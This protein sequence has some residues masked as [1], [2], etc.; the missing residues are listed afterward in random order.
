MV[1]AYEAD[2]G[3]NMLEGGSNITPQGTAPL[4]V[5]GNGYYIEMIRKHVQFESAADAY[6]WA[7]LQGSPTCEIWLHNEVAARRTASMTV[8]VSGNTA[9]LEAIF[10][11]R[12]DASD[13][14]NY[15]NRFLLKVLDVVD[16]ISP[17]EV[18]YVTAR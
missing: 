1:G 7:T 16:D 8:N 15:G 10:S 5:L 3:G 13:A 4:I 11:P 9:I 6:Y 12:A 18:A 17:N 2:T 14:F